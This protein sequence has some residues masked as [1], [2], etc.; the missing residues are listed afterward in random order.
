MY[1]WAKTPVECKSNVFELLFFYI[2]SK[3]DHEENH[4][5]T[6]FCS[7]QRTHIFLSFFF[8]S[9]ITMKQNSC[10]GTVK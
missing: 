4:F 2:Y 8:N 9:E 1:H 6:S 7:I 5:W 10:Q 3:N